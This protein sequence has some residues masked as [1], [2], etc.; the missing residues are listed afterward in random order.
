MEK[1]HTAYIG[2]GSNLGDRRK[3]CELSLRKIEKAG[4]TVVALS[5][6]YETKALSLDGSNEPDYINGVAKISTVLEPARLLKFLKG[7]E[8]EMGRPKGHKRW[9]SRVIDLDILFYD[10]LILSDS[11]L[12]IPHPEIE[13]RI[14]VLEPLCDIEPNLMHPVFKKSVCELL[15]LL[16]S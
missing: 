10:S 8:V 11:E 15:K 3:N 5:K 12:T 13:K 4:V 14:F 16:K 1:N 7:I 2:I 9:D 6:W